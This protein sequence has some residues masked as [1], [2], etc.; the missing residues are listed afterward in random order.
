MKYK[1]EKPELVWNEIDMEG[2]ICESLEYQMEVDEYQ[3]LNEE[4]IDA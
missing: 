1:Y 4:Y 3:I 2:F